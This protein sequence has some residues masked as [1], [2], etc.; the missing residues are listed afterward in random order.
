MY[1]ENQKTIEC[2]QLLFHPLNAYHSTKTKVISM[3]AN[4]ALLSLTRGLYGIAFIAVHLAERMQWITM[5]IQPS[6]IDELKIKQLEYLEKFREWVKDSAWDEIHS[7]HYDWWMFPLHRPSSKNYT[8]SVTT[9]DVAQLK[10]DINFMQNYREGVRLLCL[11]WGW[12]LE[13]NCDV[14]R[15][16][17]SQRWTKYEIRYWKMMNSLKIFGEDKLRSQ[18]LQLSQSHVKL[19]W[20]GWFK[21][22]IF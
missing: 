16:G 7:A 18:I 20:G 11:A 8:Y 19:S 17:T 5:N 21:N 1:I 12:D 14:S 6:K 9:S 2:Y 15:A 22:L 3:F 10:Q 4:I 13:N